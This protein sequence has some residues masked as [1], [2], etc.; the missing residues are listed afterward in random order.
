M[1]MATF[2]PTTIHFPSL[3][4]LSLPRALAGPSS[5]PHRHTP[6]PP[7]RIST[8]SGRR[9]PNPRAACF[10]DG[11]T[12]SPLYVGWGW[13]W[14]G[15]AGGASPRNCV[16]ARCLPRP[17][18]PRTSSRAYT[19]SPR[20]Y[21]RACTYPLR[22]THLYSRYSR[23]P[24]PLPR[25]REPRLARPPEPATSSFP[26]LEGC[27]CES[28]GRDGD[29]EGEG[30]RRAGG[31][32]RMEVRGRR[33]GKGRADVEGRSAGT[34]TRVTNGWVGMELRGQRQG[35][36]RRGTCTCGRTTGDAPQV[37]ARA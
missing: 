30:V 11:E 16:R 17:T 20:T 21:A 19:R 36:G 34:H 6:H 4:V 37:R 29:R 5:P 9:S 7:G 1:K 13:V 33:E 24:P 15:E 35:K 8:C 18:R 10:D 14:V 3:L 25:A 31:W 26:R 22:D 28:K 27:G 32:V 23:L 12:A 2:A